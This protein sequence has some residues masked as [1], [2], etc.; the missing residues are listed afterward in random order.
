MRAADHLPAVGCP[1]AG[2]PWATFLVNVAGAF[3]LGYFIARIL[4]RLPP[5]TYRRPLVGTGSAQP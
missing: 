5:S 1:R 2:W 4:E 3:L